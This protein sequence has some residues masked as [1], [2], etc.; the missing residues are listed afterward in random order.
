M[1]RFGAHLSIG[2][3]IPRAVDRA[4]A[5]GCDALQ[6]FTKSAGQWRAR[7][8]PDEEV[9]AFRRKADEAALAPRVAHA[10][11]LIN[12]GTAEPVLRARSIAGLS[13][14]L[15][16]AER[17]GL[18]GLVLHP[19]ATVG[20]TEEDG[21]RLVAEASAEVLAP[22]RHQRVKLLFEHTAGQGSSL[23]WRFEHLQ[24][25][26]ERLDGSPKIG[27]CLDTCHLLAAGYDWRT[28]SG[29]RETFDAFARLVGFDRLA[30]MHLNDSKKPCGSRVDRHEHIGQGEVGTIAFRRLVNDPRLAHMGMVLETPKEA[31]NHD[32]DPL[33]RE[34]LRVLRGLMRPRR[35]PR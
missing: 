20:G 24:T 12:L 21:L 1:P 14:E 16:R 31:D 23:G 6:I 11:Y 3:G 8:L 18:D 17:L 32:S 4:V 19:G 25:L 30:V 5:T 27:V 7:E 13:E 28:P 29:Y 33:D 2:G 34:N 26:I 15:D 35:L 10:S 9:K 22:R